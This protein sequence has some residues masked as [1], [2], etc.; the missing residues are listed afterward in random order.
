MIVAWKPLE[1]GVL[2]DPSA[3]DTLA[4]V[5]ERY[6]HTPAQIALNWLVAQREVIAIPK[7]SEKRY[8][9]ENCRAADFELDRAD[10]DGSLAVEREAGARRFEDIEL[11]VRRLCEY[12]G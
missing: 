9:D 10:F 7:A 5:A 3:N 2:A 12:S 11:A 8:I 6:G 1:R 4:R